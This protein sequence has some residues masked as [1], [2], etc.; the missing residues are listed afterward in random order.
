MGV[1]PLSTGHTKLK[2]NH[3]KVIS[4]VWK[5]RQTGNDRSCGNKTTNT[6]MERGKWYK[7][8]ASHKLNGWLAGIKYMATSGVNIITDGMQNI[9]QVAWE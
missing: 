9:G 1:W 3:M 7:T 8:I 6:K 5:K 4:K 2:Y